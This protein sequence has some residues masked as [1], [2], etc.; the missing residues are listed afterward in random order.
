LHQN[1]SKALIHGQMRLNFDF[2]TNIAMKSV[3][4]KKKKKATKQ[5]KKK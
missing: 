4:C 2:G 1:F 3:F 5:C